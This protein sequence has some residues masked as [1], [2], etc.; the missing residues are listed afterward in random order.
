[1]VTLYT[2]KPLVGMTSQTTPNGTTTYYTYDSFGRLYQ[3]KDDDGHLK[4]KYNYH[5][6]N[7]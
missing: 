5:Y 6:V 1:M 4:N 2:Y 3:V 7:N